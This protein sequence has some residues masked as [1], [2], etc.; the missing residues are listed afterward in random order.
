MLC[1]LWLI[2]EIKCFA[3]LKG[4]DRQVTV[5]FKYIISLCSI[6]AA[7]NKVQIQATEYWE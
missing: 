7:S 6:I 1:I 4:N 5:E 2:L 3:E